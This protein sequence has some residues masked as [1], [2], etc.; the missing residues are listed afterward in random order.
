[1]LPSSG[2][3]PG[4]RHV[5]R[6]GWDG[7]RELCRCC[8]YALRGSF[9]TAGAVALITAFLLSGVCR[10]DEPGGRFF[11]GVGFHLLSPLGE[12]TGALTLDAR[13]DT[14]VGIVW[15]VGILGG[16]IKSRSYDGF[17]VGADARV[18]YVWRGLP[19]SPYFMV[20]L[21][22]LVE[23]SGDDAC[24]YNGIAPAFEVGIIAGRDRRFGR[25]SLSLESRVVPS[26]SGNCNGYVWSSISATSL[27]VRLAL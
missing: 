7:R 10:A 8:G 19:A 1:M 9:W 27:A 17:V 26:V 23:F 3:S 13:F 16:L 22:R 15:G 12:P 21:G 24:G 4:D 18:G 11:P 20:G 25:M 6:I 2:L 14:D 5:P